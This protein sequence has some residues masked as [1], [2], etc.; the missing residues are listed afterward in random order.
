MPLSTCRDEAYH[1][2]I[3]IDC[4]QVVE[5][6]LIIKKYFANIFMFMMKFMCLK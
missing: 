1:Q 2:K 3:L 5:L 6:R 4:A